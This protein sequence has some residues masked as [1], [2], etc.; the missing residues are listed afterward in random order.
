MNK[1]NIG[2]KLFFEYF[3][4]LIPCT[5]LDIKE[6]QYDCNDAFEKTNHRTTYRYY[7]SHEFKIE[8]NNNIIIESQTLEN[9]LYE[10]EF[11]YLIKKAKTDLP[12]LDEKRKKLMAESEQIKDTINFLR[13][14]L[15]DE[16][17]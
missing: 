17:V 16:Q 9:E 1:Y 11:D 14:F 13:K 6:I 3:Y 8:N 4:E 5:I 15:K 2:D 7:I 12:E 10:N